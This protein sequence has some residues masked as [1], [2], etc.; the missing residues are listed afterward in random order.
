M[1][2]YLSSYWSEIRLLIYHIHFQPRNKTKWAKTGNPT[3]SGTTHKAAAGVA[4]ASRTLPSI[5]TSPSTTLTSRLSPMIFSPR[6]P[7]TTSP[8]QYHRER[9]KIIYRSNRL[10]VRLDLVQP[11]TI[12]LVPRNLLEPWTIRIGP[13]RNQHR[14]CLHRTF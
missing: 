13:T 14:V 6:R 3:P 12:Q 2:R 9:S 5:S 4:P 8:N 1:F 7:Q 11:S 10:V